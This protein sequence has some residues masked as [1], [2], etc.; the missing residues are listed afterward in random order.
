MSDDASTK[1]AE[2]I[3]DVRLYNVACTLALML[4]WL[5]PIALHGLSGNRKIPLVGPYL[6]E[7]YRVSCLFT[8]RVGGWSDYYY[9]VR[10]AGESQWRQVPESDYS[11]FEPFS[12]RTRFHRMLGYTGAAR[13]G[14][15]QRQQMAEFIRD[16]YALLHPDDPPVE[17][18]RF[19]H[20]MYPTGHELAREQGAWRYK[21]WEEVDSGRLRIFSTHT[22]DGQLPTDTAGR[23]RDWGRR[24]P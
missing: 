22:F 11:W 13:H 12:R 5:A 16:R 20:A 7:V 14:F 9:E 6:N 10:L 17:A 1:P 18:V 24:V 21:P 8:R 2:P 19:W 3:V 23:P 4:I 15:L